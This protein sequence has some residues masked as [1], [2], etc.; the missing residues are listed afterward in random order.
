MSHQRKVRSTRARSLGNPE[1]PTSCDGMYA[2]AVEKACLV[3]CGWDQDCAAA[4]FTDTI[5]Q[6]PADPI[7]KPQDRE[8]P[9]GACKTGCVDFG[10]LWIQENCQHACPNG[11]D[12]ENPD[13]VSC[14]N[15]GF[16]IRGKCAE[17]ICR[18]PCGELGE[19]GEHG[20]HGEPSFEG[21]ARNR[22]N[23]Q[24]LG[25][26]AMKALSRPPLNRQPLSRQ[27]FSR[28]AFGNA[29]PVSTLFRGRPTM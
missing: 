29:R 5:A 16:C 4:C 9:C 14:M 24:A 23:R 22:F 25:R 6:F 28:Q 13:C 19:H 20:E 12:W 1:Q 8:D 10:Q 15:A 7:C 18:E 21:L 17:A 2:Y 26:Q 11:E 3:G 27:A